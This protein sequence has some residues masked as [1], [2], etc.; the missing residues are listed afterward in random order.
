MKKTLDE[1]ED[2]LSAVQE[3][4]IEVVKDGKLIKQ[5]PSEFEIKILPDLKYPASIPE[6]E[7]L[8]DTPKNLPQNLT[9][10]IKFETSALPTTMKR[11]HEMNFNEEIVSSL[12]D[13]SILSVSISS[14]SN[15]ETMVEVNQSSSYTE[16]TPEMDCDT[17]ISMTMM[18][19]KDD[20]FNVNTQ[21]TTETAFDPFETEYK[22]SFSKPD[23][24]KIAAKM[25]ET[26]YQELI[27]EKYKSR[28]SEVTKTSYEEQQPSS[29]GSDSFEMLN[30]PDIADE[31]VII[32]EVAKEAKEFD[33]EGQSLTIQSTT[34]YIRKHDEE[35]EKFIVKSAP[36]QG[37]AE[38][39]EFEESPQEGVG[40]PAPRKGWVE[41]NISDQQLRYP[42]EIDNRG[43]LEDIKEED[44]DFEVG[45]SRLSSFRDSYSST[46]DYEALVRKL[47]SNEHENMS[48]NSLQE[49]ESLE[50]VISL[51]NRKQQHLPRSSDDSDSYPRRQVAKSAQGDDVSLSSLKE[52]EGL[53]NACIE[54]HLLEIRAKEEVALLLSRS[55]ESS[56]SSGSS[57]EQ[58]PSALEQQMAQEFQKLQ[59]RAKEIMSDAGI[60]IMEASTDSLDERRTVYDKTSSQNLSND[61]L[62]Q[63]K[64]IEAMTTSIDSIEGARS[65]GKSSDVDSIDTQNSPTKRR[66]DS[67][68]SIEMMIAAQEGKKVIT[69]TT[70]IIGPDGQQ[71]IIT[72]TTTVTHSEM[73][74][75]DISSDS[76]E[77]RVGGEFSN[78][79]VTYSS[80]AT[81]TETNKT[82]K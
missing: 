3:Q 4:L 67:S 13:G 9:Q 32:E 71:K 40:E 1:V 74:Q 45:S 15:L 21:I 48:M 55:D 8:P 41:M 82:S 16:M 47:H 38:G 64:Q 18:T 33:T 51:E 31:F 30:E 35:M 70:T 23:T 59:Q 66:S 80:T 10:E 75:R 65:A 62:D 77:A 6:Q 73:P 57:N 42:Y 19:S 25:S 36:E 17:P 58:K 78:T 39:F 20:Q 7:E 76:L 14:A 53:E 68:D 28:L 29:P 2:S 49:F 61:S 37:F 60:N 79:S 69:K 81:S 22:R 56:K 52:F 26:Q 46:P 50:Q 11:S 72:S 43:I 54:A 63:I 44:T 34:K 24:S 27:D 5:S 12:D